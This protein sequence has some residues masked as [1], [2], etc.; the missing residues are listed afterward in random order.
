MV[1]KL[2]RDLLNIFCERLFKKKIKLYVRINIKSSDLFQ[3]IVYFDMM[4]KKLREK[5]ITG[6]IHSI[7]GYVTYSSK[8]W[9]RDSMANLCHDRNNTDVSRGRGANGA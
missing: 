1:R 9:F 4:E 8:V 3:F 2:G 6:F 5:M 7:D